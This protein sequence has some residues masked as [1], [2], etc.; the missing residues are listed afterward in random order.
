MKH[1]KELLVRG[2]MAGRTNLAEA[3]AMKE[4]EEAVQKGI[5]QAIV[6]EG[7]LIYKGGRWK[8]KPTIVITE[9]MKAEIIVVWDEARKMYKLIHFRHIQ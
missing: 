4:V 3:L 2:G 6:N 1:I 9:H 8:Y 5:V 7:K